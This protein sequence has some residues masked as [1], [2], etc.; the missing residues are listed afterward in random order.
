MVVAITGPE[1]KDSINQE[2]AMRIAL[3][4]EYDG[5]NYYGSQLQANR[6]TIQAEI[7]KALENLTG[8]KVHIT[9]ASRTDTGVHAR[10]QLISF[11]TTKTL[12]LEAFIH[13]LNHHLP[14]DIAV[15]S[16]CRTALAFN[17]RR[18]AI[19]RVY[20]YSIL[21]SITRSPLTTRFA[22]RVAGNLDSEIM[23]Y[24]C[25]SLVGIHDFASFA[26]DIGDKLEKSTIR[27]VYRA[28]VIRKGE[29]II[30]TIVA[31]A[32]LRHQIRN[33]AGAL[34]QVGLGKISTT[35]FAHLLVVKQPGLAGPALPACGLC[36]EQVN[37]PCAIEE[38][39]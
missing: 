39:K 28:D 5:T 2:T 4:V 29:M 18:M 36:L 14:D 15:R 27:N 1:V 24:A 23:N 32:F 25:Q 11:K 17:P 10:G 35:E 19:S 22:H 37:Y 30:F 3:V 20:T 9:A 12:P 7:E 26:S 8:E 31:N 13:G 21:N 38:M 6:T 33:T 16:A 34:V